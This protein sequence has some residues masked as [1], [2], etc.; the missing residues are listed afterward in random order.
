MDS[1][2]ELYKIGFGPSSSHTMGP[3]LAALN[4]LD[5]TMNLPVKNYVVELYGSLAATGKGHLTDWVII[6]TLGKDRTEVIF[7]PDVVYEFHTNGMKFFAF[8]EAGNVL[9]DYLVFSVG[10]GQIMVIGDRR[11]GNKSVYQLGSMKEIL[12]WCELN[13]KKIHEY[14]EFAEGKAIFDYL[15]EIWQVMKASVEE[16]LERTDI[17]P[18][19]LQF[20]RRAKMFYERY[21][22][23][24]DLTTLLYASSEAVAEQNG[25]G[26]K[27]VTA[28]TCGASGALPG[29]LY[30]MQIYYGYSDEEIIKALATGGMVGNLIKENG[31]I[32]GAEAGCQAEIGTA[33]SM[34]AAACCYLLGG[35]IYHVEYAAE[36]GLEHHLGLTCD[37]VDGLV[38]VPCIERNPMAARRAFDAAKYAMLTDGKHI[39]TLDMAI[40]TMVETGKDMPS[41][42]RETSTGG[43]AKRVMMYSR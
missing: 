7:K 24:K 27:I 14:V 4:F 26:N 9:K 40:D 2:R 25:S 17:L 42:Y 33:C 41:Q 3:H 19:S 12:N 8:D 39:I 6:K 15:S 18:G 34:A 36:I 43:L 35:D 30:S 16:G 22:V 11:K 20:R 29:L 38:Q 1:L 28:P 5:Q 21:L 13:H 10:G 32:S 37:P 23:D 31:S